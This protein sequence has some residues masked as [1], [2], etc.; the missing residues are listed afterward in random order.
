VAEALRIA[1]Q[2]MYAQK[3]A[4]R[5]SASRQS[6]DVLLRAL[7]ERNPDLR[8]HISGVAD[9]AEATALRLELGQE[10]VEQVRHAAELH[11]IG[12][13][14]VPDAILSKPGP[15][16]EDEW[17]FIRR[18]TLIGQRIVAAA[19]ALTRVAALVRS[20]HER[21]DG[22]GYPDRLAR[23]EIPLGSRIVAVADAFDAMISP[24]PY[25]TP[26]T[27]DAALRE[28]RRC[29]GTQFDPRVVEAFA[30]AWMDRGLAAAA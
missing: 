28:L 3:N 16:D 18:H 11:D 9:L 25:S 24:R 14:A 27:P 5:L 23:F 29:A 10:E 2:R 12:K 20:S 30:A 17:A 19:P 8:H 15:L 7:A 26:R 13:M 22:E 6:K 1:D 21:W 4:G